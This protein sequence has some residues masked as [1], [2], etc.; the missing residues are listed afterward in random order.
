MILD[1]ATNLRRL[2]RQKQQS[3]SAKAEGRITAA[4]VSGKGGVGKSVVSLYLAHFLAKTGKKVLLVDANLR[5]PALHLMANV[6][7]SFTVNDLLRKKSLKTEKGFVRIS[8][9][10]FLLANNETQSQNDEQTFYDSG[11]FVHAVA[12]RF[13]FDVILFDTQ[14]GLN[15]WNLGLLQNVDR[16]L[17]LTFSEPTA[18]IDTYLFLKA[19]QP[20]LPFS[21]FA[22]MVNQTLQPE[23]GTE[24]HTKLNQ[25]LKAF[26]KNE[27]HLAASLPF[28][29]EIRKACVSQTPPW[30]NESAKMMAAL[31]PIAEW[32]SLPKSRNNRA[33]TISESI[34]NEEVLP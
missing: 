24:A 8:P 29:V 17:L 20:Y 34:Q 33:L 27:I 15:S 22:L 12:G 16:A 7:A 6:D 9:N 32:G 1:Q 25:A 14:T 3:L 28:D 31:H 2:T 4:L 30:K 10:L 13:A 21:K 5:S 18:V 26:L 23:D 11:E 19:V